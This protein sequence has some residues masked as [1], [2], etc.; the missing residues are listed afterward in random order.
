MSVYVKEYEEMKGSFSLIYII[1]LP[2]QIL[3]HYNTTFVSFRQHIYISNVQHAF[4]VH[5]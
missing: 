3:T 5:I 2:F 1:M 4:H